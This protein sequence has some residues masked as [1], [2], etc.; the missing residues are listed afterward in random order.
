MYDYKPLKKENNMT[1]I[2]RGSDWRKWDLHFHTPSSYDYA[3]QSVT[4]EEIID[5][6]DANGIS[7]VAITDHHQI[8]IQRIQELQTLGRDKN[9]VV[10]P[11]IE[12][13]SDARGKEPIHFIG[14][15]SEHSNLEYIW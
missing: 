8:D 11:G 4:N 13:L 7:V 12:F 15:F 1:E 14:I 3:D 6:L 5:I 2:E 9:I 10:L